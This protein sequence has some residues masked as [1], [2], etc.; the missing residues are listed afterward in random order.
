MESVLSAGEDFLVGP[1]DYSTVGKD[2]AQYVQERRQTT[3]FSSVPEAGPNSVR[4]IK[5]SIADPN[6]F[7]DLA[8]LFFTWDVVSKEP[9]PAGVDPPRNLQPLTAIPHNCFSRMV[10]RV[11]SSLVEDIQYLSRT[12][13]MLSRFMS[14][15][16][17]KN[18]ANMGFGLV[19]GTAQGNDHLAR[20]I[21]PGGRRSVVW[22]PISSG[23]LNSGECLPQGK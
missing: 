22:R 6:G 1:L 19:S 8:S 4:S 2:Q 13:E 20:P 15:E 11:S 3:I 5:F 14:E 7:L 18:M 23:L 12:E 10:V 16:K 9:A 21:P 17:R